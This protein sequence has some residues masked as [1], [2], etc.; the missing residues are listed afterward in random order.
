[1][2]VFK[3]PDF[4]K[5]PPGYIAGLT[6]GASGFTTRADLGP[7]SSKTDGPNLLIANWNQDE[8]VN[9]ADAN[10]NKWSG[11]KSD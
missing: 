1:M 11:F 4:G 5:P 6:W 3:K 8:V 10:Y 9:Y 2:S 7:S